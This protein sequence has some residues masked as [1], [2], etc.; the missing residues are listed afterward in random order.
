M[1]YSKGWKA[2][3]DGK[4]EDIKRVNYAF[5][6]LEIPAGKHNITFK[7]EPKVVKTGSLIS[8]IVSIVVGLLFCVGLFILFKRKNA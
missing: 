4:E 5:R 2:T 7:F 3:I 8:L 6:G 1:Y